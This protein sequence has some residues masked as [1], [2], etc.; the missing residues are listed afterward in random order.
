[1]NAGGCPYQTPSGTQIQ[2]MH[3]AYRGYGHIGAH[4]HAHMH[5][6]THINLCQAT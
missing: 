6:H 1:M 4:T 2:A 3:Q 5:T